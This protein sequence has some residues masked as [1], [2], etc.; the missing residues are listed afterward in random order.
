[1]RTLISLVLLA[2]VAFG[3][4]PNLSVCRV[5][6]FGTPVRTTGWNHDFQPKTTGEKMA[7][8]GAGLA[9][10]GTIG[11]IAAVIADH[12]E[13]GRLRWYHWTPIAMAVTG[14]GLWLASKAVE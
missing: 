11:T 3:L 4:T 10:T 12:N 1:M 8:I 7:V 14:W 13:A 6:D 9:W 2:C 5:T